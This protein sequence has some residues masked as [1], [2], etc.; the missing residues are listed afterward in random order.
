VSGGDDDEQQPLGVVEEVGAGQEA[1]ALRGAAVAE[2]EQ[3]GEAAPGRAVDRIGDDVGGAVGE[4]E[5]GA[6]DETEAV[7]AARS[8]IVRAGPERH[9]AGAAGGL[10]LAHLLQRRMGAH[11]AGDGVAIGEAEAGEAEFDGAGDQFLR[12]RGAAQEGEVAGRHP[13]GIAAAVG[14]VAPRGAGRHGT[15]RGM[16]RHGVRR[17]GSPAV[18]GAA[19]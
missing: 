10:G 9:D 12:V 4:G 19:V 15:R 17:A 1:V 14:R 11:H 2:G 6:D 8:A 3:A 7:E 16:G 13:F 18:G 5:A